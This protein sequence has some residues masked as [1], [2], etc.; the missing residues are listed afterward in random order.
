MANLEHRYLLPWC[1]CS[2]LL[3]MNNGGSHLNG[4]QGDHRSTLINPLLLLFAALFKQAVTDPVEL[5]MAPP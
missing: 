2:W 3:H 5:L 4:I 1:L